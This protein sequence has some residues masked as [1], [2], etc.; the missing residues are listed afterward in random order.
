MLLE[1][2]G[3]ELDVGPG[4]VTRRTCS[5]VAEQNR[6]FGI[7]IDRQPDGHQGRDK[8]ARKSAGEDGRGRSLHL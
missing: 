1:G 7:G 4:A 8:E 6:V 2:A 5:A 3:S